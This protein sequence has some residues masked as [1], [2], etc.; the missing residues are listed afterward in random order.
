[1]GVACF[2]ENVGEI[3]LGGDDRLCDASVWGHYV[4]SYVDVT[5]VVNVAFF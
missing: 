4:D 1:M 2:F 5:D 3:D